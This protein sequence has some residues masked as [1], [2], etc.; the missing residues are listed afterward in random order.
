MET[1]ANR[2]GNSGVRRYELVKDGI[3]LEFA[4]GGRY[5]YN[6]REPG[7]KHI[8]EMHK[9]ALAGKGLATYVN[10]FVREHY[11]RRLR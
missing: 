2:D 6:R 11:A 1:Y 9:R 7:S 5:Y 3:V 8:D 4:D 10:R